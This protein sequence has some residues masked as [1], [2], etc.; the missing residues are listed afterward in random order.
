MEKKQNSR[1]AQNIFCKSR[2][3]LTCRLREL[4]LGCG[5]RFS[6]IEEKLMSNCNF[7]ETMLAIVILFYTTIAIYSADIYII[8][9]SITFIRCYFL[10]ACP[11]ST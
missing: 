8:Y 11:I 7:K 10:K 4:I 1:F 9:G 3:T 5:V 6:I 2:N